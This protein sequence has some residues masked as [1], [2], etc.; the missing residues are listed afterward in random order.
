MHLKSIRYKNVLLDYVLWL[1]EAKFNKTA[2]IRRADILYNTCG[3]LKP[4]TNENISWD[5]EIIF[6]EILDILLQNFPTS[7]TKITCV[8]A[9]CSYNNVKYYTSITVTCNKNS[10]STFSEKITA[11]LSESAENTKQLCIHGSNTTTE[12]DGVHMFVEVLPEPDDEGKFNSL[13]LPTI[14]IRI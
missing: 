2:F 4:G 11:F 12:I 7:R 3:V 6:K 14:K 10:I 13:N 8:K 9:L 5:C 1:L